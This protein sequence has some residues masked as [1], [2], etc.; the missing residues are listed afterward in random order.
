MG[1]GPG[2]VSLDLSD[3]SLEG[4]FD[5]TDSMLILANNPLKNSFSSSV[6]VSGQIYF[7][8]FVKLCSILN[9][10]GLNRA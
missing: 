1:G 9:F 7:K 8:K 4:L 6:A 3:V 2:S 10:F 5:S